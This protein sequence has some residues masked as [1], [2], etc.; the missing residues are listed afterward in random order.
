MPSKRFRTRLQT[1]QLVV[2]TMNWPVP[3]ACKHLNIARS[4]LYVHRTRLAKMGVQDYLEQKPKKYK[5]SP[6]NWAKRQ[7]RKATI[8]ACLDKGMSLKQASEV[9][10][11]SY[12]TVYDIAKEFGYKS[13]WRKSS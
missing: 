12:G 2:K 3:K 4:A 11:C 10:K 9:A 7:A 13:T 8:C 6:Y 5:A 1:R